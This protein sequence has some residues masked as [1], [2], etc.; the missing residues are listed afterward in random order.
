MVKI[1]NEHLG[2]IEVL[3]RKYNVKRLE[4]F[5]SA[6]DPKRFNPDTSDFDFLVEFSYVSSVSKLKTYMSLV[7]DL[8]SLLGRHVDIVTTGAKKGQ[9]FT[10]A[11]N[12]TKELVYAS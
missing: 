6:T 11:I 10:Q 1:L 8:E 4:L 12:E 7:Y 2:E 5:G 3:C 9:Y